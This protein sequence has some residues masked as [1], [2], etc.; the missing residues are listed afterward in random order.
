MA[1]LSVGASKTYSTIAA[2]IA[3]AHDGDTINV[4]AGTGSSALSV[5]VDE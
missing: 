4:D 1:V 2:A 5:Q 3:A